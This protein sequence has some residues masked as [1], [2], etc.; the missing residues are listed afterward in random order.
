[1]L[2]GRAVATRQISIDPAIRAQAPALGTANH[3]H[4]HRKY[5]LL[6]GHV[7]YFD[8]VPGKEANFHLSRGDLN[9]FFLGDGLFRP[10]EKVEI[11][12]YRNFHCSQAAVATG[13]ETGGQ[14]PP[15][16]DLLAQELCRTIEINRRR[17]PELGS[18]IV[19]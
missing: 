6:G 19:Q 2:P 1:L 4:G 3:F 16:A 9:F 18:V 15:D 7:R 17:L 14:V 8:S 12:T 5:H 13:F 11:A 10:I